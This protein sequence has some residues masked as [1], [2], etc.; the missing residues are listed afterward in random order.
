MC[1]PWGCSEVGTRVGMDGDCFCWVA[2]FWAGFGQE[3][4]GAA[5]PGE[6][7]VAV[8]AVELVWE[9]ANCPRGEVGVAGA[10]HLQEERGDSIAHT[11]T[12]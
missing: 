6:A 7:V 11:Q 12:P 3:T 9:R 2:D 1:R 10:P 4:G 8:T 5:R